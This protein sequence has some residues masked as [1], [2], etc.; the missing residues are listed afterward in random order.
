[1]PTLKGLE[2]YNV[3]FF[4]S[5]PAVYPLDIYSQLSTVDNLERLGISRYFRKEIQI[6]LDE[7]YR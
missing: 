2:T 1:M 7:T 3:S 5:A 6:V 4:F